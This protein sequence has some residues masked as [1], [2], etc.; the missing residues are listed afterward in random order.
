[1]HVGREESAEIEAHQ[2]I[3]VDH[4]RWAIPVL[5][6]NPERAGGAEN[7]RLMRVVNAQA[8]C[9]SVTE[10]GPDLVGSIMEIDPHV[11]YAGFSEP[12]Q[13]PDDNRAVADHHERFWLSTADPG[14][15]SALAGGKNERP[16]DHAAVVAG[17]TGRT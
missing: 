8:E 6:E 5:F 16:T 14:N 2:I 9:R 10:P 12:F 13:R 1:P 17:R 7:L 3:A 4:E 15:S 11:A